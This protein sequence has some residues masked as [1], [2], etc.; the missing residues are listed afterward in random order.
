M[1]QIMI[2]KLLFMF[3]RVIFERLA[4]KGRTK[5][6]KIITHLD[7]SGT[8]SFHGKSGSVLLF[9]SGTLYVIIDYEIFKCF[10]YYSTNLQHLYSSGN[11]TALP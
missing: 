8:K 5:Y 6:G 1:I 4:G 7:L 9:S 2:L 3:I 11:I 10:D